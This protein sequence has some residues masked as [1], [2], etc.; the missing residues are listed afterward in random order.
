MYHASAGKKIELLQAHPD[1]VGK[2]ALA[3]TLSP[4]STHEQT[5]AGLTT[6][7]PDEIALFTRLNDEYRTR[8]NFPFVIC[9]RANKKESILAGFATRLHATREQEMET[10][11][12]EVAK[13][14]LFRLRD[15][16]DTSETTN[17]MS[18]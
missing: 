7:S 11:L 2:A 1:L 8:F 16:V 3:G 17:S 12:G 10:A 5:T 9:A 18:Q 13:I 6:L 4:A 14:C 15:L